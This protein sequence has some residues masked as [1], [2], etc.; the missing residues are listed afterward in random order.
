MKETE[1]ERVLVEANWRGFAQRSLI[2][3]RLCKAAQA[4]EQRE[5]ERKELEE[6]LGDIESRRTSLP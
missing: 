4:G 2:A 6:L 5:A 3:E 1:D